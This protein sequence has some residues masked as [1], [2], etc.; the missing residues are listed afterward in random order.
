MHQHPSLPSWIPARPPE[1]KA[2]SSPGVLALTPNFSPSDPCQGHTWWVGGQDSR[3]S[4]G[5]NTCCRGEATGRKEGNSFS[6]CIFSF[7]FFSLTFFGGVAVSFPVASE[8]FFES[9]CPHFVFY[10]YYQ[11][12][13]LCFLLSACHTYRISLSLSVSHTHTHTHTPCS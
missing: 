1:T 7:S 4:E 9:F 12:S 13:L 6:L 8:I 5:Q 2:P 11:D 3:V 10:Q